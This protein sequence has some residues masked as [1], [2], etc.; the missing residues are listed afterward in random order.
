[1]KN[2][3][4]LLYWALMFVILIGGWMY[5]RVIPGM[6]ATVIIFLLIAFTIMVY[7]TKD[8]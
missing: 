7:M 6:N 5:D 8:N 4:A 1:M 3:I 2:W